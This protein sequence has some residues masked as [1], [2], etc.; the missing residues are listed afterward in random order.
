MHF[1]AIFVMQI[2]VT[3]ERFFTKEKILNTIACLKAFW[4]M[5]SN[6]VI[7]QMSYKISIGMTPQGTRAQYHFTF[8]L[9]FLPTSEV[10]SYA[11]L[12]YCG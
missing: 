5:E 9:L 1:A 6:D 3:H 2:C 8:T 10:G 4:Y 11:F 7:V 12:A